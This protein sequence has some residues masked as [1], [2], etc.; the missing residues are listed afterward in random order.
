MKNPA[1]ALLALSLMVLV[2]WL[3]P[4]GQ[5]EQGELPGLVVTTQASSLSQPVRAELL[6]ELK[7]RQRELERCEVELGQMEEHPG[8]SLAVSAARVEEVLQTLERLEALLKDPDLD[9]QQL[10]QARQEVRRLWQDRAASLKQYLALGERGELPELPPQDQL[11]A[12]RLAGSSECLNYLSQY[13]RLQ[14]EWKSQASRQAEAFVADLSGRTER[15][16]RVAWLR[17]HVLQRLARLNWMALFESPAAWFEDCLFELRCYPDRKLGRYLLARAQIQRR[18]GGGGAFYVGWAEQ[19]AQAA[20]GLFLLGSCLMAADRRDRL[21]GA[22]WRGLWTWLAVWPVCQ[23]GL[24]LVSDGVTDFLR[25]IFVLGG[26]YVFYRAYQ[27]LAQGPLLQA[28]IASRMGQKVGVRT[29][30]R[31]HLE[32]WGKVLWLGGTCNAVA[33]ALAGPGLLAVSSEAAVGALV[34]LVYWFLSWN[35]RLELGQSLSVLLPGTQRMSGWLVGLC[36]SPLT[37]LLLAPLAVPLVALLEGLHWMVRRSVRYDWAKRMSAGVLRRWMES[38]SHH[39]SGRQA[40]PDEYRA[41]F[42]ALDW[43]PA[44]SWELSNPNFCAQLEGAVSHWQSGSAR[45]HSLLAVHGPTGSGREA[46]AEHLEET[47]GPRLRVV[48]LELPGRLTTQSELLEAV[49][50]C[51][52]LPPSNAEEL[53]AGLRELAP[54]LLIIPQAQRLFLARLGGFEAIDRLHQLLLSCRARVFGCL[55]FPSQSL[56]YLRLV[57]SERW[58]F[59]SVVRMPRWSEAALRAMLL[60]RHAAAGGEL[61]FAPAVLRAAEATPG[62]SPETCFFHILRELSGGNPAVACELWLEAARLD[63]SSQV[64]I[65]LPPRKPVHLLAGLPGPAV[66]VLAAV[67]RH[68]E[69]TRQQAVE[70]TALPASQLF[71]AWELCQELGVLV[72]EETLTVHSSWLADLAHF[73]KERNLLDGE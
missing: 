71:T 69:L 2:L 20:L 14:A 19:M 10:R 1:L 35:W 38:N 18:T 49:A 54:T 24:Y 21:G 8:P 5:L 50:A 4:W 15:L 66:Y 70:V 43:S 17:Y 26:L 62:V 47:F 40:V 46:V 30:A 31:Q 52:N 36:A 73:L 68:G 42:Q 27:Q 39:Q 41:T 3:R 11:L 67:V 57:V 58:T 63:E 9:G 53:A 28:I 59:P 32:V 55:I 37:G 29:R 6:T 34:K 45:A 64:V 22:G 7:L 44:P 56:R 13:S 72:G 33:L 25:P 12:A 51:F 60:A 23:L 16:G 65:D 61:R 48:R